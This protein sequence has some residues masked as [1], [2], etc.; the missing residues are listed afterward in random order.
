MARV[1]TKMWQIFSKL[2]CLSVWEEAMADAGN[3]TAGTDS[4][5][6]GKKWSLLS[7]VWTLNIISATWKTDWSQIQWQGWCGSVSSVGLVPAK[8]SISDALSLSIFDCVVQ[9]YYLLLSLLCYYIIFS[10]DK[11]HPCITKAKQRDM[12]VFFNKGKTPF[13]FRPCLSSS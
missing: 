3:V 4:S 6:P 1:I 8:S 10:L 13:L 11:C 12:P 7:E 5:P 9:L 2:I